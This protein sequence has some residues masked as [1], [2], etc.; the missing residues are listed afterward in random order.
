[1]NLSAMEVNVIRP[2]VMVGLETFYQLGNPDMIQETERP[3]H[4]R[5]KATDHGLRESVQKQESARRLTKTREGWRSAGKL[6][7]RTKAGENARKLT[8][9]H[10]SGRKRAKA[11]VNARKLAKAR[12]R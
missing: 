5:L 6:A 4:R 11:G 7:K 3:E 1:L 9:T 12:E 10:E 8:K 2:F